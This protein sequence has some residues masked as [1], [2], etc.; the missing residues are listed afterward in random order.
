MAAVLEN[1]EA[2][3]DSQVDEQLAQ[4]TS[5]IRA[6]DLVLGG[7][8]VASLVLVYAAAM[9]LL[10]KVL[11][12]PEAVRQASLAGFLAVLGG[13]TYFALVRPM[14]RRINPLYAAKQVEQTLD[15]NKNS[16]TGYVDAQERGD[17]NPTVKAALA[18]RAARAAAEA[19]VNRAVNH[20][21]LVYAGGVAVALLL[22]LIV[23]FFVFR[24]AQFSSLLGR[25]FVPFSSPPIAT[26]TELT[27]LKPE[28]AEPT[29]TTGQSVTV[30]VY[31]GGRIP[32]ADGPDR[33]RLLIRHN[34]ESPDY[35]E[36]PMVQGE[37]RHNWELRVPDYLVQNGFWYKVTAGDATTP[38]YRVTVRSLPMFTDFQATY[39]YPAYLR[40]KPETAGDPI[41]TGYRGTKVTLVA[42]ANRATA[43]GSMTIEAGKPEVIPGRPVPGKPDS[44]QFQFTLAESGRYK[45]TFTAADGEPIAEP[46][47]S[48]IAVLADRAPQLVI[49]KPEEETQAPANGQVAV[50]GK[51]GDDFG[52]DTVT[53][54]MRVLKPV[55]RPLPDAPYLN[56]TSPSFRREKD[57][58]YPTDL[59]YKGSVDLAKLTKDAAGLPL[60]LKEDMVLEFWLEA[61]DNCTEPK[62]NVGKSDPKRV[63]LTPPVKEETPKEQLN[64]QKQERQSEEQQHQAQQQKKLDNENRDKNQKGDQGQP[65]EKD[66][67]QKGGENQPNPQN[68]PTNM[69][70]KKPDDNKQ[71]DPKQP[72]MND[73]NAKPDPKE[74]KP[75]QGGMGGMNDPKPGQPNMNDPNRNPNDP[76]AQ[77]QDPNMQPGGMGNDAQPNKPDPKNVEKTAQDLKNEIEKAKQ[78]AGEGKPNPEQGEQR[79]Q[80]GESKPKP[81]GGMD[82][83]GGM[84]DAAQP[85]PEPKQQP[86]DPKNPMNNPQNNPGG[87]GQENKS[88]PSEAKPQG[89]VQK[90]EPA[91]QPKPEPKQGDPMAGRQGGTPP[92]E[93]REQPK[94]D[95][96]AGTE[97]QEPKAGQPEPKDPKG[98][99]NPADPGT[100]NGAQKD[101]KSGSEAKPASDK[102]EGDPAGM[103]NGTQKQ[104]PAAGAAGEPKPPVQEPKPGDTKP[105]G[106]QKGQPQAGQPKGGEPKGGEKEKNPENQAGSGKPMDAPKPAESKPAPKDDKGMNTGGMGEKEGQPKPS[107]GANDPK[108][109][110]ETGAAESKPDSQQPNQPN[111]PMSG[112]NTPKKGEEKPVPQNDKGA[113]NSGGNGNDAQKPD[114]KQMKELEQAAK[115]L[116]SDDPK[117]REAAQ[118]KLDKAIGEEKRKEMEQLA[119]DLKSGDKDKQAAAQEK[120]EKMKEQMKNQ[121]AGGKPQDEK[122]ELTEQEKKE[123]QDA[124]K[125][126]AGNDEAKKKAAREKLDQMAGEQNRK[127]AEQLMDDLKSDD[128]AKK[129]AAQKR[130]EDMKKQMEKEAQAKKDQKNKPNEPEKGPEPTGQEV[131][132][133]EKQA[134]D[135]QSKDEKTRRKAQ[136]ALDEQIGKDAREKLEEQLKK[137]PDQPPTPQ[138][139]KEQMEKWRQGGG[140]SPAAKG[141]MEEDLRNRSR[142]AQQNLEDFK[143]DEY[144][145]LLKDKQGWT[146]A[147]YEKFLKDYEGYAENLRKEASGE[148]PPAAGPVDLSKQFN[149]GGAQKVKPTNPNATT[150]AGVGGQTVAPPGF[151]DA[152]RRFEEALKKKP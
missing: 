52:I 104:D 133:V 128:K 24:P 65:G 108:K 127:E 141:P 3:F 143:K 34:P 32:A 83:K 5:R 22:A 101:P 118:Q 87:M 35:E 150:N 62:P 86:S 28:P 55:E 33:V 57:D 18:V 80:P 9:I 27:L 96:P 14:R 97:K 21:S 37:S 106:D 50:D 113:R 142:S 135:L 151:E 54:K 26:Q 31:V 10:D 123:L 85:K 11:V 134:K 1:K 77:P 117:K 73:P 58:T 46:F 111:Q 2:K 145:K 78:S 124:V 130:L 105:S 137:N 71:P 119:K 72:G 25:A 8:V 148:K 60:E 125:D 107:G 67:N 110:N 112:G 109:P 76:N 15:D 79:E 69:G 42:K 120:L 17:L 66:P 29:I 39:E 95:T 59:D 116:N 41:I 131:A 89:E 30:A 19:D 138:E 102:N 136:E 53:L 114:E 140:G 99:K 68:D 64:Q 20:R 75:E 51:V 6:H 100:K 81:D 74:N 94:G 40:R 88:A 36:L 12:L 82:G 146:D 38:E 122:R 90:P 13:V 121:Q 115:D 147:E 98:P 70:E 126:L 103:P 91:S 84:Q 4:A 129:E 45:L 144:R 93:Q 16:V 43:K 92:A 149:A 152:R 132:D 44:L 23:L 61:A 48:S 49:L 63:R 7:L 47:A 139:L 56:G